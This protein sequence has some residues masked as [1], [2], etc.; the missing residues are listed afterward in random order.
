[1]GVRTGVKVR[2]GACVF[3]NV[4]ESVGRRV[5]LGA[6]VGLGVDV[7]KFLTVG[8]TGVKVRVGARV[9]V[10]EA[11]RPG[12]SVLPAAG[13]LSGKGVTV[14][15][16]FWLLRL[17]GVCDCEGIGVRERG[18]VSEIPGRVSTGRDVSD[19]A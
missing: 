1:M 5:E 15:G 18:K 14:P 11:V 19:S 10:S 9:F 16:R 8:V 3:V 6:M 2:V 7:A 13:V 17:V 12:L 4:G